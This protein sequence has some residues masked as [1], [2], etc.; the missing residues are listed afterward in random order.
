MAAAGG[1]SRAAVAV[2]VSQTDDG[3]RIQPQEVL[4]QMF[5][6]TVPLVALAGLILAVIPTRVAAQSRPPAIV[7]IGAGWAGFIDEDWIDHTAIGLGAMVFVTDR[8]ALGPELVL[9]RG[10]DGEHGWTLTGTVTYDLVR[11]TG[12]GRR[13]VTPYLAAGAGYLSQTTRVGTGFFTSGEGTAS[14]GLGVRFAPDDRWFIAP[15]VRLGYE[16]ELRAL[17][18]IGVRTRR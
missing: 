11:D 6:T 15:E 18:H 1:D 5:R 4:S 10:S 9:L 16:P 8:L 12:T 17:V 3:S 13:R 2:H 14:G 7:E